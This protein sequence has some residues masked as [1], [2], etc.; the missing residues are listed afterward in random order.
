MSGPVMTGIVLMAMLVLA[1][2]AAMASISGWR[3]VAWALATTF[4]VALVI[5]F[6]VAMIYTGMWPWADGFWEAMK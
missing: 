3:D 5:L 4:G 1:G 2:L 6:A